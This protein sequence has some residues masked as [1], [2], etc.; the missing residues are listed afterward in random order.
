MSHKCQ[1]K[2]ESFDTSPKLRALRTNNGGE[3]ISREF[4]KYC[5]E[6]RIKRELTIARTPEQNGVAERNW[7]TLYNMARLISIQM[8]NHAQK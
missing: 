1:C 7:R 6:R 5:K 4:T 3:Y 8:D 2:N